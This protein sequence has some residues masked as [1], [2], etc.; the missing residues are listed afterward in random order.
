LISLLAAELA[1]SAWGC[2]AA[3]EVTDTPQGAKKMLL[4]RHAPACGVPRAKVLRADWGR[5]DLVVI[6][7]HILAFGRRCHRVLRLHRGHVEEVAPE[8]LRRESRFRQKVSRLWTFFRHSP[9]QCGDSFCSWLASCCSHVA[10]KRQSAEYHEPES[11]R[12]LGSLLS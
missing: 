6:A 1:L 7:T 8:S 2:L 10:E 5:S 11:L 9:D 4:I 3:T 12:N